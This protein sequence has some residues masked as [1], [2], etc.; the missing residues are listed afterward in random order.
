MSRKLRRWSD[1]NK[2]LGPF[3]WCGGDYWRLGVM[4]DSG[5]GEDGNDGCHIRFYFGTFTF[6]CE[7]PNWLPD[8]RIKHIA[9]SWDEATIARLGRNYYYE[10]FPREYG[11]SFSKE[12]TLHTH[13]GPQTHDS[14]T[15]KSR[16]YFLPWANWRFIGRKWYGLNGELLRTGGHNF[17]DDYAFEQAMPK[18]SFEFDDFDGK[19]IQ[20][21]TRIEER[22][23]RFGTGWFK[24]LSVFRKHKVRRSLDIQFSEEVGPEKG[25]WKGGTVGHSIDMLP[26]ELHE[27]AFRRYCEK[28]HRSKYRNFKI[29]YVGMAGHG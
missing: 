3:T 7:L 21:A 12:G 19:R 14:S 1:D 2:H 29:T 13:Y 6:I 4:L 22:E 27:Q 15:T 25:S 5:A 16:C 23:W 11:F 28:E 10:V 17:E 26:G 9:V 24:W 8:F 20:A 18:V